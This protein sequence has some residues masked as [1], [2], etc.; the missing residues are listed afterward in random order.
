MNTYIPL[1]CICLLKNHYE[2]IKS[3]TFRKGDAYLTRSTVHAHTLST[4][5]T[6]LST[7][8]QDMSVPMYTQNKLLCIHSP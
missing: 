4:G 8:A 6:K 7:F 1:R 3:I 5:H 2:Y